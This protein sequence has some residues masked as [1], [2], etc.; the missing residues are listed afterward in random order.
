CVNGDEAGA[1]ESLAQ[2]AIGFNSSGRGGLL[3]WAAEALLRPSRS[4][5]LATGQREPST[6]SRALFFR[7]ASP[8]KGALSRFRRA[9]GERRG[10]D[11][12]APAL[13]GLRTRAS[14]GEAELRR[15]CAP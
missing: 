2:S 9:S 10:S 11:C 7:A 6:Y 13:S 1:Q 3:S 15:L 4:S 8:V 14:R 5:T 12:G